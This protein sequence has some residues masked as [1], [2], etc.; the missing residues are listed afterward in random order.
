MVSLTESMT[1]LCREIVGQ[2]GARLTFIH[3]LGQNVAEMKAN[4]GRE[5][6]EM[7]RRTKTERQSFVKDLGQEVETLLQRFRRA[8]KSMARKT[9]AERLAAVK[10]IKVRVGGMCQEFAQDLAGARRAWSGPSPAERHAKMEAEHRA[11]AEAERR[12]K[13]EAD[14]RVQEAAERERLAALAKAKEEATRHQAASQ[15]K[16]ETGR[17]GKKK[18]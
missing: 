8:H 5:H 7:A 10:Q 12:V 6:S 18:G 16:G 1:R 4:L 14:R 17:P 2:R 13:A 3:D 15:V 11:K 9:K